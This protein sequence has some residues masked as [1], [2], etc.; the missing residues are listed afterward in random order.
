MSLS[1]SQ[2]S[3]FIQGHTAHYRDAGPWELDSLA[4]EKKLAKQPAN[5]EEEKRCVEAKE[6]CPVEAIGDNGA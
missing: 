6:G 2:Q 3:R 5:A 4:G 1:P